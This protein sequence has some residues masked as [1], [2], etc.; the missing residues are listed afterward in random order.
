MKPAQLTKL[1][2][3]ARTHV[4]GFTLIELL[5]VMGIIS[6]LFTISSLLLLNLIPKASFTAQSEILISE[7][8]QQQLKAMTGYTQGAEEGGSYG[9][10]FQ[11]HGYTLFKGQE[12]D[13]L[14]SSNLTIA[15]DGPDSIATTLP[16]N[17]L[18]FAA[19][20]GE[21]VGYVFGQ[22]SIT[23]SNSNTAESIIINL[24]EYGVTIN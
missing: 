21:V 19:G 4:S 7:I 13:P 11:E 18:V 3:F 9:I 23:L 5:L 6:V 15:V 17:Q 14:S 20:S 10:F 22:N 24:N 8:R 16:N 2:H 12:Y 1:K